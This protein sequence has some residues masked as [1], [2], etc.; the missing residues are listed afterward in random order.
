MPRDLSLDF[1][2]LPGKYAGFVWYVERGHCVNL[3]P[4]ALLVRGVLL[5]LYTLLK[6]F[7][8]HLSLSSYLSVI[9]PTFLNF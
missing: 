4:S 3:V 6:N 7:V 2:F 9:L 5:N 8:V 1:S